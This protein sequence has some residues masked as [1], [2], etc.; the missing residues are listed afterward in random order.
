MD[1]M[2]ASL[3]LPCVGLCLWSDVSSGSSLIVLKRK[4]VYFG[5]LSWRF[6]VHHQTSCGG[7]VSLLLFQG[8]TE[9][10]LA[11]GSCESALSYK[12]TWI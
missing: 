9:H 12:A 1:C 11:N 3:H 2:E 7:W 4:Q 5:S 8:D 10:L 6:I